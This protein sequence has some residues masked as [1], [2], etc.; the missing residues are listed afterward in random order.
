MRPLVEVDWSHKLTIKDDALK[1]SLVLPNWYDSNIFPYYDNMLI[2]CNCCFNA[3]G[4]YNGD[5][6]SF[7]AR[8]STAVGHFG[9]CRESPKH[10][11][12]TTALAEKGECEW[13]GDKGVEDVEDDQN[14]EGLPQV[15]LHLFFQE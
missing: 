1:S 12:S 5:I 3:Q 9:G 15:F 7:S 2:A 10:A 8:Q 13:S 4:T 11:D 14:I 6:D